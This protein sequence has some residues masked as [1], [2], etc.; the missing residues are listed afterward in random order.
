MLEKGYLANTAFYISIAH[1][2]KI[3]KKYFSHLEKI[4]Q[5]IK[6]IEDGDNYKKYFKS[7]LPLSEFTR[8]N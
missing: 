5:I 7:K 1:T 6:K 3:L 4:F 8:F 2:D